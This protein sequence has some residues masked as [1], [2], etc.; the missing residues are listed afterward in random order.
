MGTLTKSFGANGGYVAAEKHII[1][2]LKSTNAATLLGESPTPAVLMQIL[3]SLRMITG[4][5]APGQGE[6]RLQRIAFNSRYLRLG[7]KRL[8]YIVYGHDDSPIVPIMLYN[9]RQD[10]RLQPRDAEAPHLHRHRRLSRHAPD[11]LARPLLRVVRPQQ[12]RPRPASRR[13]RRGR[14]TSCSSRSPP[15]SPAA[16]SLSPP[17]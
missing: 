6:E 5:L 11:H 15:A 12:G 10:V 9:P 7:L 17:A 16:W 4:E 3:S 8:G 13:L 1:A 2:K 14:A